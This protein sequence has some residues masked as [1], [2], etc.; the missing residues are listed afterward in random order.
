M[1]RDAEEFISLGTRISTFTQADLASRSIQYV[2][3]SEEEKHA[4]QF[5]FTVSDGTNEVAQTFYITIKPVEDSLPLLQVPG[6]R[7]QEGVRKTITEFEL[8]ATD[9]DTEGDIAGDIIEPSFLSLHFPSYYTTFLQ[10]ES[11]VFSVIQAPRHSTI[12]RTI[13]GQHYRQI[14]SFTM[15]DIDQNRISYNHDGSNSLKYRFTFTV[16]DS[17]NLLFIVEDNGKEDNKTAHEAA[18]WRQ[19]AAEIQSVIH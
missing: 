7:V 13:S 2:H 9:A 10:A 18:A 4:D 15:D 5:S 11:I 17:T 3:T 8:K 16:T 1:E 14:S 19:R 12:K 6:M